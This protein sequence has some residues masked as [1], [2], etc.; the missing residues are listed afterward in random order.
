M[1]RQINCTQGIAEVRPP[2]SPSTWER[3]EKEDM[4]LAMDYLYE[5]KEKLSKLHPFCVETVHNL[6]QERRY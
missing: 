1:L 2:S 4:K 6:L 5:F 3:N